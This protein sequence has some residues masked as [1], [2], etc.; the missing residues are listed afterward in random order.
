MQLLL[1][2]SSL[3]RSERLAKDKLFLSQNKGKT[4]WRIS[5]RLLSYKCILSYCFL[6]PKRKCICVIILVITIS[7]RNFIWRYCFFF[8]FEDR[9]GQQITDLTFFASNSYNS[10][11]YINCAVRVQ[12]LCGA[13]TEKCAVH[14]YKL[15]KV[16]TTLKKG[17]LGRALKTTCL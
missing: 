5:S 12:V 3:C 8:S 13:F 15:K 4:F 7:D 17:D 14:H 9:P 16:I 6:W 10:L 2:L 11:V 1:L